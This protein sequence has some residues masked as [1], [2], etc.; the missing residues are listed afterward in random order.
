MGVHILLKNVFVSLLLKAR[1]SKKD[2]SEKGLYFSFNAR[3]H[4]H[5]HT[6]PIESL[7]CV[8]KV[9]VRE[10]GCCVLLVYP[11]RI[12]GKAQTWLNLSVSQKK[13]PDWHAA[14]AIIP[15]AYYENR[16]VRGRQKGSCIHAVQHENL[17]PSKYDVRLLVAESFGCFLDTCHI[18]SNQMA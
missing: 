4:V 10:I 9:L 13:E 6:L 14:E 3:N 12:Y 18:D 11:Y 5:A 2:E 7:Q 17:L 16:R 1:V 15:A 8:E